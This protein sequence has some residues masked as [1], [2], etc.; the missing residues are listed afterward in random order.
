M[1]NV[2]TKFF[3]WCSSVPCKYSLGRPVVSQCI[4]GQ[5]VAFQ[6]HSSVHWTSQCTLAQGKGENNDAAPTT[7]QRSTIL[8]PS[9]VRLILEVWRYTN[10]D[11][12]IY[13]YIYIYIYIYYEDRMV[14]QLSHLGRYKMATILH[15]VFTKMYRNGSILIEMS[16]TFVPKGLINNKPT[17]V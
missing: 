13:V 9:K 8:L 16:L 1:W 7:S 11:I 3:Q 12:C 6:W 14:L 4:L 5:P 17:M 10:T 2:S 15:T